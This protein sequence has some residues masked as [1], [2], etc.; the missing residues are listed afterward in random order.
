M[1]TVYIISDLTSGGIIKLCN[2]EG[3]IQ[4]ANDAHFV[5]KDM[6]KP[7]DDS[8]QVRPCHDK[9]GAIAILDLDLFNVYEFDFDIHCVNDISDIFEGTSLHMF[10]KDNN[11]RTY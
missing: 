8:W 11:V 6:T 1:A 4:Y 9:E 10:R 7:I 5:E 3:L 2:E